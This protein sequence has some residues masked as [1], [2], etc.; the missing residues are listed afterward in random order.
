MAAGRRRFAQEAQVKRLVSSWCAAQA[1]PLGVAALAACGLG[2]AIVVA[3]G[4]VGALVAVGL[5]VA[6]A[7]Q[8]WE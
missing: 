4:L 2:H 6:I 1:M 7:R 8:I 3:C 5:G